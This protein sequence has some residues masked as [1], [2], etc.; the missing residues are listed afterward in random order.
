MS[1]CLPGQLKATALAELAKCNKCGFC[2]AACPTY[3]ATGVEWEVARGRI[4]LAKAAL[5][6]GLRPGDMP[7]SVWSCLLCRN[8]LAHCPPGV[9]MDKVI[10]ALR[11]ALAG[12]LGVSPVRRLIMGGV[13]PR[14]GRLEAFVRAGRL[15]Q[16]VSA[17]RLL[18]LIPDSRVRA[19]RRFAPRL[20]GPRYVRRRAEA[21]GLFRGGSSAGVAV[22]LGCATEFGLPETALS[23]GRLLREMDIPARLVP[24]ACCGLPAYSWGDLTGAQRAARENTGLLA[25]PGGQPPA[26]IITPC[27]SC[28]SFL[29]S[30]PALFG[31]EGAAGDSA[32]LLASRVEP[33]SIFLARTGLPELVRS[34]GGPVPRHTF[35]DPCHLAHHLGLGA[36]VRALLHA[37]P[38]D[39]FVEMRDS[40]SCC[41]AAGSFAFTHPEHAAAVLDRKMERV[42]DTGARLLTT[43]CPACLVQL[44][45]GARARGFDV[46]VMHLLEAAWR[47]LA[48][49]AATDASP[50]PGQGAG[51]AAGP[52]PAGGGGP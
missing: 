51:P 18:D 35:H 16:A 6:G 43:A 45:G 32:G 20:C 23:L 34:K 36:G 30:Y 24:G 1:L 47:S 29:R 8:C 28:A 22:F 5:D 49:G 44:A 2:L 12:S 46:K 50:S 4:A 13:L 27:A 48:A 17:D 41:G 39:G 10:V 31:G 25:P 7:P 3:L 14:R 15:A 9:E 37:L 38:G 26:H 11:A 33:A 42:V 40:D 52:W 21:E 19:A